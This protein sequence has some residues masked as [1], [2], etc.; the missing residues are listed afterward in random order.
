VV[1][2][3]NIKIL[4]YFFVP[5]LITLAFKYVSSKPAVNDISV[6]N[7]T[8]EIVKTSSKIEV[9]E[10]N[11][12]FDVKP[13]LSDKCYTCH[14]PDDKARQANLRLDIQDGFYKSLEDNPNHYVI[15]K[16]NPNE[17]EILK[18]INSENSI[19]VMPP[20]ES[21]LTLSEKEKQIL[22]KWVSQ[23]GKWE[24]HWAYTKPELPKVP[25]I[26]NK[27]WATNEIDFFISNKLESKGMTPSNLEEKEILIRR[28]YFDIIGLPPSLD[29]IDNFISD[30][31]ENAYE[32]VID[33]LLM[34]EAYGER[35]AA[36]WMDLSRY[37]DSHGYQD[38]Q[39]RI[40]WPW[41]DW[42]IH[43]Y[44]TNIPYDKFITW[45]MAG[46]MLPNATKEQIL[47]S[48]F[49]RNHKITQE[50]GVVPEEYRVEY[51]ADRTVT[52]A[53]IMMGLTVEC[54]RCHTHKYDPISHDEFFSLYSFFNNVDEDGLIGYG[55]TAPKPNLTINKKD[56]NNDLSFVSLPDSISDVT[57][58]V[59][60]ET[61]N[62]RNTYVLN[63]GSYDSPTRLVKP[64]T[65]KAVLEFDDNKYPSNRIG[66]SKWFF[67]K[68]NPLTSR[69][70]VNRL[71]QQFFGVGIVATPDDFGS[72]GN[73]PV[74]PELLDWLAY[75]FQN[76]DN[77]DTKKFIKRVVMSSTYRQS[78]KVKKE[79]RLID[80]DNTYLANYPRQKLSAEMIRDNA[81]ATSKMLVKKVG[82]PSVKPMQPPGLW[83][84]VTGG[85]G[86]SLAFYVPD[87]GENLYR[88][89]LY[90]FWKRTVPPPSMMIF[91][92]PTRD[93]CSPVRQKTSTP[94][95]SLA[96]MN[97]PQYQLAAENLS[98][99]IFNENTSIENKII[100]LYRTVTGRTP[101]DI[102]VNKLKKYLDEIKELN[103]IE[104]KIAFNSLAVL[105]YNLDETT[106]KS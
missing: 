46:D 89:S 44:N 66:L 52:S 94:L 97:D 12:N 7:Q 8:N 105:V 90:T 71:W 101:I 24:Q 39:E 68:D 93:F 50:G 55:I 92:A 57:L 36:I 15:N 54:A 14:G 1:K 6:S 4:S 26:K 60:K 27:D 79:N 62:L 13:I 63:R 29:E 47:A 64:S 77:W 34:S 86:G 48:G 25:E 38:D 102:E 58:M 21:N 28:A 22:K 106:Q 75:T 32:K 42:V 59:M 78:S 61:E 51:V 88:R 2:K 45:Q 30:K 100:K 16:N 33:K 74:N 87:S 3:N 43:A 98:E 37:G 11:F 56:I 17:S 35:M 91:D 49:N 40:M 5:L 81:L 103:K 69:V 80:S 9:S 82:G 83:D 72:Q 41:R 95:Q 84:E 73:K 10:V 99:L 67:D 65:P 53:K 96:L 23:G 85:G 31:S 76:K 104:D 20:P 70:T 18:R 19:Y